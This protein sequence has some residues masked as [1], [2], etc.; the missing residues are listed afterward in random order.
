MERKGS[1]TPDPPSPGGSATRNC[2]SPENAQTQCLVDHV[3]QWVDSAVTNCQLK[4]YRNGAPPAQGV[5]PETVARYFPVRER[6]MGKQRLG[7]SVS[8]ATSAIAVAKPPLPPDTSQ[9]VGLRVGGRR[10]RGSLSG[11]AGRVQ[12]TDCIRAAEPAAATARNGEGQLSHA[13]ASQEG[14][15]VPARLRSKTT[16]PR[17]IVWRIWRALCCPPPLRPK[18]AAGLRSGGHHNDYSK[19]KEK[20]TLLTS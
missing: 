17:R 20:G 11:A 18:R 16:A 14:S 10:H 5:K 4:K 6:T 7:D 1:Q 13:P 2:K 3:Q 12:G 9:G 8:R 19:S 15:P